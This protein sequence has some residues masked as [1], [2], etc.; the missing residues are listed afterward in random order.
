MHITAV[1]SR[2]MLAK[3]DPWTN[4]LR[5]TLATAGAALGGADAISVYPFTWALGEPDAFARRVARNVQIVIQEESSLGRVLDPMGGS[6]Y[7]ERLTDDL[8]KKAWTLFQEIEAK[9]GII[10]ALGAGYVQV[11]YDAFGVDI[12][13]RYGATDNVVREMQRLLAEG[14]VTPAPLQDPL[15]IWLGYQG[16]KGARRAGRL[17]V[18]LLSLSPDPLGPY[19]EGLAEGGHDPDSARMGGVL[20]LIVADDPEEVLDLRL[21]VQRRDRAGERDRGER[22]HQPQRGAHP[23]RRRSVDLA[24]FL[25]LDEGRG[26]AEHNA[27]HEPHTPPPQ[28]GEDL[29]GRGLLVAA[30]GTRPLGGYHR[31]KARRGA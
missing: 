7:I 8:A 27:E 9:G 29:A 22:Q 10:S 14:L 15:P 21:P 19:R 2:H 31:W 6:W 16:P 25:A 5:S 13:R 4:I 1:S 3:R 23:E 20:N 26:E 18:G 11:E 28:H 12:N 17:G 24:Q 30:G